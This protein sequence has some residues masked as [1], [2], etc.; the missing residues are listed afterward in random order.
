MKPLNILKKEK[1]QEQELKRQRDEFNFYREPNTSTK[2]ASDN[3]TYKSKHIQSMSEA[4]RE[5][6]KSKITHP[7]TTQVTR[8]FSRGYHR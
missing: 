5:V 1:E 3:I 4:L 7:D 8:P 2:T 6:S